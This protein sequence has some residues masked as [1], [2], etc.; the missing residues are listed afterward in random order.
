M[1]ELTDEQ[2]VKAQLGRPV[3]GEIR[4]A[5]RCALG[6]P[7]VVDV[8]PV[9]PSGEPFPT[10]FW[11]TCPLA[12]RRIARLEEAGGVKAMDARVAQDPEFAAA[13]DEAHARYAEARDRRVPVDARHKPRGG[14]AGTSSR[15]VKCLHAHYADKVAGHD[16]PVG[17]WVEQRVGALCCDRPC[18]ALADSGPAR[19]P[20]WREPPA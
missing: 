6:L 20:R 13:L 5:H 8:P 12:H 9:L 16:N 1:A 7:V 3:R 15:G 18:V 11:L 4:V 19:N 14:V 17:D 2:I 10:T